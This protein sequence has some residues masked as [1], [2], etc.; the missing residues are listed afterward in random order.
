MAREQKKGFLLYYDYRA[1]LALLSDEERGRLLMAL[2]DYSENR[3]EPELEGAALMA[4][5]F[6]RAQMDRDAAKYA[7]TVRKRSE[8]GKQ[9][10]RPPK[11]S[12]SNENQSEAKK[13]NAFS[14][15][16]N[17]A[18]KPD[19]DTVTDTETE[20]ETG[21]TP[22]INPPEGETLTL[23]ERRFAEFWE[24]Y[25]NKKAKQAA[26]KA[27]NKIKP[28]T[29][30]FERIMDAVKAA[31]KSVEWT[32]DNGQYIPHP[33][34]WLN[35]GRWDDVMTPA[36]TP[37]KQSTKPAGNHNPFLTLLEGGVGE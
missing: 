35:Q 12:E 23:Q 22:P 11:P 31:K 17:E 15:K 16:Q 3:K 36:E 28:N 33:A 14:E 2:L 32:K 4:Y 25:P 26:L 18:R 19:T 24:E 27:W 10:G 7:E 6:I 13:A 8:A 34:T 29:E 1:H 9:G 20:T 37:E 5:S 30:L 21:I